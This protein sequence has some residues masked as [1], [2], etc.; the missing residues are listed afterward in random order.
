MNQ[1][2]QYSIKLQLLDDRKTFKIFLVQVTT[3]QI[4]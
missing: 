4:S 2:C 3:S 1:Q